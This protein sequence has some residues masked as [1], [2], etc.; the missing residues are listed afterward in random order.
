MD[1]KKSLPPLKIYCTMIDLSN[2]DKREREVDIPLSID[3]SDESC[4]IIPVYEK[5]ISA[6]SLE[7]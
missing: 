6:P 4:I 1:E 7:L 3:F 2:G 5:T